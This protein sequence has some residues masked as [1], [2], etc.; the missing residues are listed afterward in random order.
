M[1]SAG[2]ASYHIGESPDS[3]STRTCVKHGVAVN[4]RARQVTEE[5]FQKFDYLLAMDTSNLE[6]LE[7]MAESFGKSERS[8][9]G[10]GM[11]K[12]FINHKPIHSTII[13]RSQG[14]RGKS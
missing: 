2:T 6:D 8:K 4:H 3:R 14:T 9:L 13:W 5:D 1:H 7:E 10:R 12:H 11:T